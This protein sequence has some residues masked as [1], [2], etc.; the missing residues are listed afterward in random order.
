MARR[1]PKKA[2]QAPRIYKPPTSR[3]PEFDGKATWHHQPRGPEGELDKHVCDAVAALRSTSYQSNR[4]QMWRDN[5]SIYNDDVGFYYRQEQNPLTPTTERVS[6]NIARSVVDTAVSILCTQQPKVFFQTFDGSFSSKRRAEGLNKWTQGVF[7]EC[8]V[9]KKSREIARDAMVGDAGFY[10]ITTKKYLEPKDKKAVRKA[11]EAGEEIPQV[12]LRQKVSLERALPWDVLIPEGEARRG[13]EHLRT[14]YQAL[15][16]DRDTLRAVFVDGRTDKELEQDGASSR[17]VLLDAID[18]VAAWDGSDGVLAGE[19]DTDLVEV[20]EAWHT[21]SYD[22]ALDGR[23]A[24][25]IPGAVLFDVPWWRTRFPFV[26]MV[27]TSNLEGVLGRGIISDVRN[28]QQSVNQQVRAI[29]KQM[30]LLA[31]PKWLIPINANVKPLHL[32]DNRAGVQVKYAGGQPPQLVTMQ[33]VTQEQFLWLREMRQAMFELP[34]VS[35]AIAEAAKPTDVESGLA[36]RRV[37]DLGKQRFSVRTGEYEDVHVNLSH[38]MLDVAEDILEQEGEYKVKAFGTGAGDRVIVDLRD[39]HMERDEFVIQA[40]AM[41]ALSDV[42][43]ERIADIQALQGVGVFQDPVAV[44]EAVGVSPDLQG[45][46]FDLT[47]PRDAI[48]CDIDAMMQGEQRVPD[49]T[50][51]PILTRQLA[52]LALNRLRPYS[53]TKPAQRLIRQYIAQIKLPD[54]LPSGL[55]SPPVPPPGA[56]MP[57]GAPT[58]PGPPMPP[59][60][61]GAAALPGPAILPA[62]P[63]P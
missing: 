30:R 53:D 43:A 22:G 51:D 6:M 48:L 4:L 32:A 46:V 9:R 14:M 41:N 3:E 31:A 59:V 20:Y 29:E 10:R 13:W 15:Q 58:P 23:H 49:D 27:W 56:P 5:L 2:E 42:P 37:V 24:L 11:Y 62:P 1:A 60:P 7:Y 40:A 34:G 44:A 8:G 36:I 54:T 63:G 21:P 12:R 57:P 52:L 50:Q 38:G 61:G 39:V 45:M 35:Q 28:L 26:G 33:P 47:A 16:I 18:K 17:E 25:V 19:Y 55:P